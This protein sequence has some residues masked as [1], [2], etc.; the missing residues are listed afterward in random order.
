MVAGPENVNS[1]GFM[2][3]GKTTVGPVCRDAG[4]SL[5]DMMLS[6]RTAGM[7]HPRSLPRG[8][9]AFVVGG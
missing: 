5:C 6:S 9:L 1:H 7:A 8:G 2:G 4:A 3:T